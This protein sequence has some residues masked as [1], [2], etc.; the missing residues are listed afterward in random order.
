MGVDHSA[1]LGV[2]VDFDEITYN[3]L[4]DFAKQELLEIFKDEGY[5][6]GKFGEYYD[7]ELGWDNV[8]Q[9]ELLHE[10]EDFYNQVKDGEDFLYNL[11]LCEKEANY[12]SGWVGHVGVGIN[13]NIDT[14]KEDV[15]KAVQEFKKVVN[16]EPVLFQGVL[17]S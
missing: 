6:E 16:L 10:L 12:Y 9:D 14:I 11:G 2:G 3:T 13:L 15:E 7:D 4:T 5:M 8:P 1:V 17:V